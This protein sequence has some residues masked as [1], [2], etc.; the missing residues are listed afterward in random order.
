MLPD[1]ATFFSSP[2]QRLVPKY[3]WYTPLTGNHFDRADP[4]STSG[5]RRPA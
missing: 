4:Q 3:G 5:R 1:L 2:P